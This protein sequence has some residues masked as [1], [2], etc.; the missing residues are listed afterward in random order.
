MNWNAVA[1]AGSYE[2]SVDNAQSNNVV[3]NFEVTT[4]ATSYTLSGL[5]AG[6]NYEFKVRTNCGG[7]HSDWSGWFN[8]TSGDGS[9]ACST[10]VNL[11]V[12]NRTAAGAQ[13]NWNVVST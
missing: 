2:I 13:L 1:G 8:F 11:T 9:G 7:N 12:T 3:Y 10:P 6:A 5:I 4:A